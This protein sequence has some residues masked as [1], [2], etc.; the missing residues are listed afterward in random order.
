MRT[1]S[2]EELLSLVRPVYL[3]IGGA[4]L[5]NSDVI[6]IASGIT[7]AMNPLTIAVME[8]VPT[9]LDYKWNLWIWD[10]KSDEYW[11]LF[12]FNAIVTL[13]GYDLSGKVTLRNYRC[14]INI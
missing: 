5:Y 12:K 10:T 2:C 9:N 14:V 4:Q 1:P 13:Y 8:L 6:V 11:L 3:D 7:T